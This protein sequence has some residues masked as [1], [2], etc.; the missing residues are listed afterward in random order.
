MVNFPVYFFSL[1][2]N[3]FSLMDGNMPFF[4]STVTIK[5]TGSSYCHPSYQGISWGLFCDGKMKR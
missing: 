4:Q 1:C 5:L 2:S 3:V